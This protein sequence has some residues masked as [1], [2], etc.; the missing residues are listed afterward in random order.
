MDSAIW[1]TTFLGNTLA[2]YCWFAGILVLGIII[3][4]FISKVLAQL[5]YR[6]VK[7]YSSGVGFDKFL[8]LLKAPFGVF[9]ILI[10]FYFAFD[11]LEF[12]NY[13]NLVPEEKF[14]IRR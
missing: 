1:N 14:G 2:S 9:V 12:P 10:T 5:T 13:W 4:A 11:R 6:L 3:K 7:K 8:E